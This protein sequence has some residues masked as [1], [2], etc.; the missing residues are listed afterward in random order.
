MADGGEHL[1]GETLSWLAI[2][3]GTYRMQVRIGFFLHFPSR[4]FQV[5][6]ALAVLG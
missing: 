4:L 6:A 1:P 2:D 3:R 5:V